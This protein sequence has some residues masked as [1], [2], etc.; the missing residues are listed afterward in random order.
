MDTRTA[1]EASLKEALRSGD[2]LRKRTIRQALAAIKQVEIDRRAAPDETAVVGIIQK[3]IKTRRESLEEARNAGRTEMAAELEVEI[4]ILAA[5]LP[6]AMTAD[7]LR[8]LVQGAILETAAASP[9]DMGKVMKVVM[10][11]VAGRAPGDQVS[12]MV[13]DLLQNP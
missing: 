11:R 2:D 8:P 13:R 1:L 12:Q 4:D 9:A 5:F 10:P 6:Q 7:E 3:E